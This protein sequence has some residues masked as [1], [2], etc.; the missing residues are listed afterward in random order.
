MGIKVTEAGREP[1]GYHQILNASIVTALTCPGNGRIVSIQA[2]GG[3][4]R[5][6]PD[7]VN[8]TNTVGVLLVDKEIHTLI[9]GG[10]GKIQDIKIIEQTPLAGA[11]VSIVTYK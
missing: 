9:M 8:P 4:V 6:R 1:N 11:K 3:G 5:Y 7:G 2:D 10:F